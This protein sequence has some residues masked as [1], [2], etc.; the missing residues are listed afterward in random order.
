VTAGVRPFGAPQFIVHKF[1]PIGEINMS[2]IDQESVRN[3][4]INELPKYTRWFIGEVPLDFAFKRAQTI[5]SPLTDDEINGTLE[6]EWATL[7]L[8]GDADYAEG[9]GAHTFIGI[10]VLSGLVKGLDVESE[11]PLFIINT[12]IDA[13]IKTFCLLNAAFQ[14]SATP[15]EHYA[16]DV[17]QIDPKAFDN[18]WW[19]SGLLE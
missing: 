1:L 6:A 4:I 11:E 8:F 12:N 13:F 17:Q 14:Q 19:W 2:Q 9:G 16:K 7:Y 15:L 5:L 10:D 18:S 3:R